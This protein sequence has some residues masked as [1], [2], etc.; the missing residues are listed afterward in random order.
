MDDK[1][2]TIDF[3]ELSFL[4]EACIP[5]RPIAR[6]CFW[7]EL[8][9]VYYHQMTPNQRSMFLN[10]LKLNPNF[11][12]EKEELIRIFEA[13]YNPDNQY[14]IKAIDGK[15]YEAFLLDDRYYTQRNSWIPKEN[16]EDI[17]KIDYELE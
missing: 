12:V 5:P 16:I 7:Q 10:W 11:D 13:R 9:D 4:A 17:K 8:I 1:C 6:T 2:F 3:F 14:K 15:E